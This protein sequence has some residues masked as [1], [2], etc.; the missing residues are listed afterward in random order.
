M[1]GAAYRLHLQRRLIEGAVPE[2]LHEGLVEY[3]AVTGEV[4]RAGDLESSGLRAGAAQAVARP[5]T[6]RC[7]ATG[8]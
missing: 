3:I 5:V 8:P 1:R 6:T 4:N 7:C 2:S